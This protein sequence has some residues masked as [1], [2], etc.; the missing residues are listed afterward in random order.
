M[1]QIQKGIWITR[2]SEIPLNYE[3]WLRERTR[4]VVGFIPFEHPYEPLYLG[5]VGFLDLSDPKL[6][7]S[8]YNLTKGLLQNQFYPLGGDPVSDRP[9]LVGKGLARRIEFEIA[10]DLLEKLPRDIPIAIGASS[11][12]HLAYCKRVG[13]VPWQAMPLEKYVA[14]LSRA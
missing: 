4:E 2:D 10:K 14:I 5:S 1:V 13:L 11:D 12:S 3:T 6:D 8:R 9:S 7:F